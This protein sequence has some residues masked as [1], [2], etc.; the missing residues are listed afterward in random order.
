MG[1]LARAVS[2]QDPVLLRPLFMGLLASRDHLKL[3][4]HCQ[5]VSACGS[6]S[7]FSECTFCPQSSGSV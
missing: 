2:P 1:H 4:A 3:Q 7:G 6:A 5:Q